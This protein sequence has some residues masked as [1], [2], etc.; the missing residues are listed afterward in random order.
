MYQIDFLLKE[1][2]LSLESAISVLDYILLSFTMLKNVSHAPYSPPGMV[3]VM[4]DITN[5][6]GE[7]GLL[8][9]WG[10]L[11]GH[12]WGASELTK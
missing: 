3:I 8:G 2:F 11:G 5:E 10:A 9:A 7:V 6:V 4:Q 12:S 1:N